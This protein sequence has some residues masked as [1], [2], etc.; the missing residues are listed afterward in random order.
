ML[1][2]VSWSWTDANNTVAT[3]KDHLHVHVSLGLSWMRMVSPVM[4]GLHLVRH[5]F[6]ATQCVMHVLVLFTVAF[7][8]SI[9]CFILALPVMEPCLTNSIPCENGQC[10]LVNGAPTCACNSGYSLNSN[11]QGCLGIIYCG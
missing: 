2:S 7:A 8:Y 3:P 4:V 5:S 10:A 6:S 1:T 11:D 9:F